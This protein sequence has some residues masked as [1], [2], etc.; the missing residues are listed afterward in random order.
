MMTSSFFD[1]FFLFLFSS[2]LFICLISATSL[3]QGWMALVCWAFDSGSPS[4]SLHFHTIFS[5]LSCLSVFYWAFSYLCF[6]FFLF[7]FS[8]S[9]S[10]SPLFPLLLSHLIPFSFTSYCYFFFFFFMREHPAPWRNDFFSL[11]FSF[12]LILFS[13]FFHSFLLL[14]SH[15]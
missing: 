11:Y 5:I 2:S 6:S 15:F 1:T 13:F 7:L 4:S 14:F 12:I 3:S 10:S 9:L 8:L